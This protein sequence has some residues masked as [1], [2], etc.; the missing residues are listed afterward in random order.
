MRMDTCTSVFV[1]VYVFVHVCMHVCMH[2]YGKMQAH[3]RYPAGDP[4][5]CLV[6]SQDLSPDGRQGR[7]CR[8]G[9][10]SLQQSVDWPCCLGETP[11]MLTQ[12]PQLQKVA[13]SMFVQTLLWNGCPPLQDP[14]GIHGHSRPQCGAKA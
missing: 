2:V 4:L 8:P 14:V 5:G 3:F 6:E 7:S 13:G 10:S 12:H 9:V 1:Y 11:R